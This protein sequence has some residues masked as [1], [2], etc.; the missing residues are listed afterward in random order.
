MIYSAWFLFTNVFDEFSPA[1][2]LLRL[3][4]AVKWVATCI[5]DNKGY[6]MFKCFHILNTL[7]LIKC[8]Y[9]GDIVEFLLVG[10]VT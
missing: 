1:K 8:I 5:H 2:Q 9:V 6:V 4:V 7:H 10:Y 3:F